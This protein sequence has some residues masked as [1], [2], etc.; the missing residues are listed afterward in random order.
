ML[1]N[2][3]QHELRKRKKNPT[4]QNSNQQKQSPKAHYTLLPNKHR[5]EIINMIKFINRGVPPKVILLTYTGQENRYFIFIKM[6][7]FVY[8]FFSVLYLK[9]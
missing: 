8:M 2:H 9:L 7:N 5:I 3:I 1:K 4:K 6:L